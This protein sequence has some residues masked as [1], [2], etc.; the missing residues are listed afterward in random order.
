MFGHESTAAVTRA[1]RSSRSTLA[2]SACSMQACATAATASSKSTRGG[3]GIG[4]T[5]DRRDV[6]AR[7]PDPAPFTAGQ[8]AQP[9]GVERFGSD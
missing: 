6:V 3:P 4:R 8:V 2:H 1:R 9:V 7:H 5:V